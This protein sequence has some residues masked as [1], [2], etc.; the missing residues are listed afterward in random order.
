MS[1]NIILVQLNFTR[2]FEH[3]QTVLHAVTSDQQLHCTVI[4]RAKKQQPHCDKD[5][6]TAA[7]TSGGD[8]EVHQPSDVCCHVHKYDALKY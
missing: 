6:N 1:K 5:R 3:D 2:F 8:L 7:I 4:V